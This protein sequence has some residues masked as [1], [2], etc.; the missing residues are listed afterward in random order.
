MNH[1]KRQQE[2]LDTYARAIYAL[3]Q[4]LLAFKVYLGHSKFY[5][6]TT[7]QVKDVLNRLEVIERAYK[8]QLDLLE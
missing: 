7:I 8:D 3:D 5:N 6:D 2:N 4:E 1:I